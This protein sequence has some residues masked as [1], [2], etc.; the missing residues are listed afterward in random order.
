MLNEHYHWKKKDFLNSKTGKFI[1]VMNPVKPYKAIIEEDGFQTMIVDIEPLAT[2][3][4]E[5][6]LIISLTKK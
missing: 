4:I 6:D 5:K 1:L 3:Q 2:E